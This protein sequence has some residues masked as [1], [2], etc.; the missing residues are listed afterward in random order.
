[1]MKI[2]SK[3]LRRSAMVL[4]LAAA[5][6]VA[7]APRGSAQQTPPAVAAAPM[8]EVLGITKPPKTN[9]LSMAQLGIVREVPVK[10]GDIVKKGQLLLA[11][12]DRIDAKKLEGLQLEANSTARI[13]AA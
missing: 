6:M 1:M 9:R 8:N 4:V 10:E 12:D 13:D 5:P 11:Q 7:L 2:S 3:T